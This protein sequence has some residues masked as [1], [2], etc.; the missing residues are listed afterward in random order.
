MAAQTFHKEGLEGMITTLEIIMT[1][2][3]MGTLIV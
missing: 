2:R 3:V 1:R